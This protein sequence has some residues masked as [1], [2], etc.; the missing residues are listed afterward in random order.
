[1]KLGKGLRI[2]VVAAILQHA[3]ISHFLSTVALRPSGSDFM[4]LQRNCSLE[5]SKMEIL[6]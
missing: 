1:M 4:R 3:G 6:K 5:T 2:W